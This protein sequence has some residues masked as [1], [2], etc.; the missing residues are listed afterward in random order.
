MGSSGRPRGRQAVPSFQAPLAKQQRVA[1][2]ADIH[3]TAPGGPGC[4]F[5]HL[6]VGSFQIGFAALGE[7]GLSLPS[8]DM[9][10]DAFPDNF[11][12]CCMDPAPHLL[13]GDPQP[14]HSSLTSQAVHS[15]L[16]PGRAGALR[17]ARGACWW[18][19]ALSSTQ[20]VALWTTVPPG[21]TQGIWQGGNKGLL[22]QVGHQPWA[23][24]RVV[25]CSYNIDQ[26]QL[27]YCLATVLSP[28]TPW[29]TGPGMF[30]SLLLKP[31]LSHKA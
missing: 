1:A 17:E 25:L 6:A 15:R 2:P 8:E 26:Q 23:T 12:S 11:A 21:R 20:A 27:D 5:D 30:S 13:P 29:S 7:R 9:D 22:A 16:K 10:R 28:T 14:Q 4:H 3:P 24:L 19:G 31:R 18:G